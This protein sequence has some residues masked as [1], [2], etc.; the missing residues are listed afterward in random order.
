[1]LVSRCDQ[2]MFHIRPRQNAQ[3]AALNAAGQATSALACRCNAREVMSISTSR[4]RSV[5]STSAK[6]HASGKIKNRS[7]RI[8]RM[9]SDV[10]FDT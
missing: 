5:K 2:N 1:M 6:S 9:E 7:F 8:L 10:F 3:R 4:L